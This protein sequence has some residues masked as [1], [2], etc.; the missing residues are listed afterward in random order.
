MSKA[1]L[2][3]ILFTIL[4]AFVLWLLWH[5]LS[6]LYYVG[7]MLVW[8]A[9]IAL[10]AY[11][12]TLIVKPKLPQFGIKK[13]AE[14]KLLDATHTCVYAFR[15]EP[16]IKDL[17]MVHNELHIAKLELQGEV[18]QLENNTAITVLEEN[19][20]AVKIKLKNTKSKDS[21]FWVPRSSVAKMDQPKLLGS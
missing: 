3:T 7:W 4:G 21:V 16:S 8:F 13:K 15:N 18:I 5:V 19:A 12:V 9:V 10:V 1:V 11:I 17:S 20:Q 6:A 2:Y 14:F